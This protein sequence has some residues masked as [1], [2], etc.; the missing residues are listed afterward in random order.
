MA[1]IYWQFFTKYIYRYIYDFCP[2]LVAD[3]DETDVYNVKCLDVCFLGIPCNGGDDNEGKVYSK[4]KSIEQ[5]VDC[6]CRIVE[7]FEN[8]PV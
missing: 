6:L 3:E 7:N 5:S 2:D 4:M 8:F 1:N